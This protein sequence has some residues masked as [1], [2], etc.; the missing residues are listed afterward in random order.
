[1]DLQKDWSTAI[2]NLFPQYSKADVE[3]ALQKKKYAS[4][5]EVIEEV[6][7]GKLSTKRVV[8]EP[9]KTK[10]AAEPPPVS[11]N[12]QL[13][14]IRKEKM[15]DWKKKHPSSDPHSQK[16]GNIANIQMWRDLDQLRS[17]QHDKWRTEK[18]VDGSMMTLSELS[19]TEDLQ[20]ET[21]ALWGGGITTPEKKK[22]VEMGKKA[23]ELTNKF[24]KQQKR[25]ELQ[26]HQVLFDIGYPHS[27]NMALKKVPFSHEGFKDRAAQSPNPCA[28]NVAM[29][30][31]I[32][33]GIEETI[34]DGW[35]HSPGHRKN[36]L[37]PDVKYCGIAVY[38][39]ANHEFY[40]TQLF[41]K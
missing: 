34:V 24:R 38:E 21:R 27:Q 14:Q 18:G 37:L 41:C 13:S 30:G 15:E 2:C 11:T 7:S 5:E 31:G 17:R 12:P 32:S 25:S 28:E 1:M 33:S 20:K 9:K 4:I 35:I 22:L 6:L 29:V 10:V 8:T 3:F 36:M 23:L 26:W 39:N 16:Q 19:K 40:F